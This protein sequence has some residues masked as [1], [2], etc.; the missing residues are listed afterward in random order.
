[1]TKTTIYLGLNDRN[2]KP[3]SYEAAMQLI[4]LLLNDL[5]G[6]TTQRA[7]GCW[8][9]DKEATLLVSYIG[10]EKS[11]DMLILANAYKEQF[12]QESVMVETQSVEVKF[13]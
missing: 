8:K 13:I 5:E 4:S 2:G 12:N 7:S 9:K 3:V 11:S 1:M 6:Y 10:D